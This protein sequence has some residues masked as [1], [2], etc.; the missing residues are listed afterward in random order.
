MKKNLT[1]LIV[2]LIA[3]SVF[4]QQYIGEPRYKIIVNAQYALSLDSTES[5]R[6]EEVFI[7]ET[8]N[9]CESKISIHDISNCKIIHC[10]LDSSPEE[11]YTSMKVVYY[12]LSKA[13]VYKILGKK[14]KHRKGTNTWVTDINGIH[15]EF[16]IDEQ[17][18]GIFIIDVCQ[19]YADNII[20]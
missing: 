1:L 8:R 19:F 3:L 16:C 11:I 14:Y 17:P 15:Y 12:N 13:Y 9:E 20:E 2:S 4:S 7:E 10:Q 18:G 6:K 5:W